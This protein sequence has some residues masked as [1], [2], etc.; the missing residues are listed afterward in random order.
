[1]RRAFAGMVWSHQH[2]A[3]DVDEWLRHHGTDSLA[4][5]GD[6]AQRNRNWFH[7]ICDDVISMPDTWEY[8]WFAAWDL[9]FHVIPLARLDPAVADQASK[10]G[11]P[12]ENQVAKMLQ[13]SEA[14]S[15]FCALM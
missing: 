9:A 15:W 7:M 2:Y 11:S 10:T 8:P 1:M 12:S 5:H 14:H 4:G 3:Y 6:P 13:E